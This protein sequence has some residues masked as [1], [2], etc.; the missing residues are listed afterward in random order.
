MVSQRFDPPVCLLAQPKA[1]KMWIVTRNDMADGKFGKFNGSNEQHL[2]MLIGES[3]CPALSFH[4]FKLHANNYRGR[5][6]S[7]Q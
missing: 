6:E 7:F 1:V 4:L 2:R 5:S 3:S